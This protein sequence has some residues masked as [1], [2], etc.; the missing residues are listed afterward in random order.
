MIRIAYIGFPEYELDYKWMNY[1]AEKTDEYEVICLASGG[2]GAEYPFKSEHI[3]VYPILPDYYPIKNFKYLKEIVEKAKAIIT[4]HQIDII[5]CLYAYPT[6]LWANAIGH[7]NIVIS[8]RGSDVLVQFDRFKAEA[9]SMM[10]K[11]NAF[12]LKKKYIQSLKKAKYLTSTSF[13]QRDKLYDLI[14]KD[15]KIDIVRTGIDIQQWN[16]FIGQ[17]EEQE[18]KEMT[19]FSSRTNGVLYNADLIV[20]ALAL[21]KQ[22]HPDKAFKLIMINYFNAEYDRGIEALVDQLGLQNEV[23]FV[24]PQDYEGMAKL[25]VNCD[26]TISI[27]SSDGT[28]NSVIES[29]LTKKPA[30]IGALKYDKDLFNEDTAWQIESFDE[31]AILDQFNAILDMDKAVLEDKMNKA[32]S[33]V[34]DIID[35]NKQRAEIERI[36]K[37]VL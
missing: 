10:G 32:R 19:I 12:L 16:D 33:I 25:Y 6:S 14:G 11:L 26:M 17:I 22:A 21:L 30:V 7:P 5:H 34:S 2:E 13:P 20:K 24:G 23:E 9:N 1:F 28:P 3:K 4:E 8:S 31:Q 37:E 27:P 29:I 15:Y 18:R 35:L 36:Y